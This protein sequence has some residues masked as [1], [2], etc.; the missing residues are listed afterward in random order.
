[1]GLFCTLSEGFC[2]ENQENIWEPQFTPVYF[3]MQRF[4]SFWLCG[5]A[6]ANA[7]ELKEITFVLQKY[8]VENYTMTNLTDAIEL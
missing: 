1:M 7:R 4:C 5:R 8:T 2:L 6:Y 3:P